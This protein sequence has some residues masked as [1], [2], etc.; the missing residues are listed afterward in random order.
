MPTSYTSLLGLALP[1]QGE[2]AGTWGD[3]VNT[4]VT[5]LIDAAIAGTTT[6]TTDTDTI[7]TTTT[8]AANQAR[9][10]V[11]LCTGARTAVRYITA[12]AASKTYVVGN[13]T[14]G[15]FGIVVRGAGP[16]AG[17]TVP[18]GK[19]AFLVW[20]GTD[21]TGVGVLAS[22][23]AGTVPVANGGTGSTTAPAALLALGAAGLDSP[24]FI[25]TPTAP[26]AAPGTNT[27]QL[28]TT[29]FATALAFLAALPAQTGN[30]GKTIT[31]DGTTASW[32]PA[33]DAYYRAATFGGF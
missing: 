19:V 14:T 2:L 25:N 29:A 7:L 10:A 22:A 12:P 30:A 8:G 18:A 23:L 28:A 24:A 16:T 17:V 11:I 1:L 3:T 6:L 31:T 5:T 20:N 4:A 15:G 13:L 32:I 9:E 33:G 26:T 27:D 21:F